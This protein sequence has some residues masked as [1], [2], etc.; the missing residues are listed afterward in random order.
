[1]SQADEL[2]ATASE[3]TAE[4]GE[5]V[6]GNMVV[7][8]GTL[9][10]EPEGNIVIGADRIITVPERLKRIAVQFDHNIETV[11]FDCPRYWDSLDMSLM[12][13]YINYRRS[14][15]VVGSYRAANVK[16]DEENN[17]LMH[18]DWTI[19]RNV[20]TAK[21]PISFLVCIKKADEDGNEENHWNSE[22][23]LDMYVS[24]GLESGEP[25]IEMY[26]DVI[27]QIEM[28]LLADRD[29]GMFNPVIEVTDIAGG[30]LLTITSGP[31]VTEFEILDGNTESIRNFMADYVA[32]SDTEP[33]AGPA[34]W[35]DGASFDDED[36]VVLKYKDSDGNVSTFYPATK[37]GNVEGSE[38]LIAHLSDEANPHKITPEQIGAMSNKGY[39][40]TGT[41]TAYL[42]EVEGITELI[43]GISFVMIPHVASF[44][45]TPTLD[46]NGL[47]AKGIRRR[48]STT[49]GIFAAG[50]VA[51]WLTIGTPIR[52]TYDGDYWVADL[53][54][55]AASDIDGEV[56]VTSGGT[57]KKTW[58]A[59]NL[60]YPTSETELGQMAVPTED[61]SVMRKNIAGAP[62]W[63]TVEELTQD[64]GAI[65]LKI[66]SYVGQGSAGN[67]DLGI[68]PKL[69]FVKGVSKD[70]S[71]ADAD[72]WHLFFQ[73]SSYERT[74]EYTIPG[75]VDRT[76]SYSSG[77]ELADNTLTFYLT[78]N[79]HDSIT[80]KYTLN[81]A[82][83]TYQWYAF[84]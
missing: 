75:G 29:S 8:F 83:E 9:P 78:G 4:L 58:D 48:R 64:M 49:T 14:D 11:T 17:T 42:V 80:P 3:S 34:L 33:A 84:Y 16:V 36:S 2:L 10:A 53:T 61:K 31:T 79:P 37:I 7:G 23:C 67:L 38:E 43:A 73:G 66:G 59:N 55:P 46:V 69:L 54:Q 41:S 76:Y 65:R 5:A 22:L 30:H 25:I 20:T 12:R 81:I 56:P 26:P 72:D 18:F 51:N 21:G 77:A 70:S 50:E 13:V 24:E 82:G 68:T 6:V 57:G 71:Y 60:I 63:S 27:Q 74:H 52:V 40:T 39:T 28:E 19:S 35:F 44:S 32:I 62:Y 45:V 1:M 15:R 47:G